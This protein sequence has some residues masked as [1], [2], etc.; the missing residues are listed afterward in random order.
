MT[1]FERY[2][3]ATLLTVYRNQQGGLGQIAGHQK[4]GTLDERRKPGA[5]TPREFGSVLVMLMDRVEAELIK[6][7]ELK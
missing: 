1:G 6:R 3:T 4:A 2:E 5:A 7:G